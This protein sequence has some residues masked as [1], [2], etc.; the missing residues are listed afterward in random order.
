MMYNLEYNIP[1]YIFKFYFNILKYKTI[2]VSCLPTE[3]K[4]E[5]KILNKRVN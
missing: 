4:T 1:K 2:D 5:M 3:S